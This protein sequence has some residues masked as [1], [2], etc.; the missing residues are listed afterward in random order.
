[1][2][3]LLDGWGIELE[4]AA[5]LRAITARMVEFGCMSPRGCPGNWG[6][7]R[8]KWGKSRRTAAQLAEQWE[9]F[10]DRAAMARAVVPTIEAMK[11]EESSFAL[12]MMDALGSV[13]PPFASVVAKTAPQQT[14]IR[15]WSWPLR[16]GV[17]PGPWAAE[18]AADNAFPQFIH[19]EEAR[20]AHRP[21]DIL[22]L[23]GTLREAIAAI[24]R[25]C[26]KISARCV[27][28][29]GREDDVPVPAVVSA[30]ANVRAML[31][32]QAVL[33]ARL[34]E[35]SG[36]NA[37]QQFA[38]LLNATAAQLS[39]N[40]PLDK[41]LSTAV[42]RAKDVTPLISGDLT[43]LDSTPPSRRLHRMA[44]KMVK[45]SKDLRVSPPV[46][47]ELPG[48]DQVADEAPRAWGVRSIGR[49]L[50]RHASKVQWQYEGGGATGTAHLTRAMAPA[51][52]TAAEQ[53]P[54]RYLNTG[55][56]DVW[57]GRESEGWV[58]VIVTASRRP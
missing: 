1:M 14:R 27:L 24:S 31:E 34:E 50:L 11:A 32:A 45:A 26:G 46:L 29:T 12:G 54:P 23:P 52:E 9:A 58:T 47:R 7:I 39:H 20:I 10:A 13:T 37:R 53:S 42:R 40:E 4:D 18:I 5:F 56:R 16:V 51:F 49:A 25:S 44:K 55:L 21:W 15:E 35:G 43:F 41:A 36:L 6:A 2:R 38:S 19:V 57:S 17:P 22:V 8:R 48:M 30:I 33:I 28:I 3:Q